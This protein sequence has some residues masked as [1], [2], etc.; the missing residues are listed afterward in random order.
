[1]FQKNREI[2]FPSYYILSYSFQ[3][4]FLFFP[5]SDSELPT[6]RSSHWSEDPIAGCHNVTVHPTAT[7]N[8]VLVVLAIFQISSDK[9]K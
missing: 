3:I 8:P 6:V 4:E 7:W 5:L 9:N 1:M 2:L